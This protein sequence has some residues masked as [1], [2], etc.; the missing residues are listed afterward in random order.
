MTGDPKM[1]YEEAMAGDPQR[2]GQEE[3]APR[4]RATAV[5]RRL[6]PVALIALV[7]LVAYALG[8][9]GYF[10]LEELA[11]RRNALERLVADNWLAA[12]F[13]FIAV[14]IAAVSVSI[15]GASIL[16]I[17]GG[18]MFGWLPGA[19][20]ALLGA[21]IGAT[22]IFLIARTALGGLI[23]AKAGP[24]LRNLQSGFREDA[25]NYLLF[26]RLAPLFPFWLVNVAPA[27]FGMRLGAY[28]LATVIG[29]MPGTLAYAYFGR[30]L[31]TALAPE[32]P[33]ISTELMIGFA[34]LALVA[35]MPV[36]VRR[37]RRGRKPA[38]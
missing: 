23:E 2:D 37:W 25:F 12:A 33:L 28:V 13:G 1:P 5:L 32:G 22:I 3:P 17:A 4:S 27:L 30:G 15:P 21:T 24:R 38:N 6:A 9:H 11:A 7:V 29:I 16:T 8:L 35:L 26:L 36:A 34:V 10:S 14:Y 31:G 18:F 19:A 20:L